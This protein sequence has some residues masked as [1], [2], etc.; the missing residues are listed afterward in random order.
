MPDLT[1]HDLLT[2][3]GATAVV[4]ILVQ[5]AKSYLPDRAVPVAALLIG[6]IVCL[7]S[8]LALGQ[9]GGEALGNAIL[10]GLLAGAAAIGVYKGQKNLLPAPILTSKPE[11]QQPRASE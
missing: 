4:T 10:I 2:L 11:S 8:A 7:L 9:S 3:G 6:I 1:L 5:V